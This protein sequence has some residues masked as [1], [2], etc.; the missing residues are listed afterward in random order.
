MR[1]G[2]FLFV[3][4]LAWFFIGSLSEAQEKRGKE[5]RSLTFAGGTEIVTLDPQFATHAHTA[6]VIMHIHETLVRYDVDMNLIPSLAESWTVSENGFIWTFRLRKGISFHDGTAFNAGAVKY[7]FDR[8]LD[9]SNGSPRRDALSMVKE[10]KVV[11]PYTIDFVMLKPFAPFLNQLTAYNLA[12]LSPKAAKKWGREYS[13][14]PAGT[15]PFKL[16][17]WPS[18]ERVV[19]SRNDQY[20]EKK[21]HHDKLIFRVIPDDSV[22]AKLLLKGEVDVISPVPIALISWLNQSKEV[23]IIHEKGFRTI[24]LGFN[25]KMKPFDDLRVRKAVSHIIDTETI[26]KNVLKGKGGIG[27]GHESPFVPGAHQG[28]RPYPY[29]PALAKKLLAEAGYANGFSTTFYTPKGRYFMDEEVARAIQAQLKEAGIVVQIETPDWATYIRLLE[30]GTDIPMFIMGK[31][32]PTADLNFT[33]NHGI[34][35]GGKMN[36]SQYSNPRVDRLIAEQEGIVDPKQRFQ[37]LY[38]IQKTI[39]DEVPNITLFYEDQILGKRR[40]VHGIEI[41]PFE[42]INL[43]RAFKAQ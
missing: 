29:D 8:L 32:S 22:R 12:I 24:Y 3:L 21:P 36:Y 35:T 23:R 41:H 11:D 38:E 17:S 37:I 1:K 2:F 30:K 16:E 13:I 34:K 14:A 7:T 33:L 39:Y 5:L 25:N 15:G 6:N 26:L 27:G 10:I 20:W 40:N 43:S 19:L 9:F 4:L 42:F 28:L 18:G 31:G